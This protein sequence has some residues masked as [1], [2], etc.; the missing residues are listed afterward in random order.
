MWRVFVKSNALVTSTINETNVPRII[1]KDTDFKTAYKTC[2]VP[3]I[4]FDRVKKKYVNLLPLFEE[5]VQRSFLSDELKTS[6]IDLIHK[7][8]GV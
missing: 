5:E 7:R 1:Y 3:E 8:L 2:G 6:Y 4:V